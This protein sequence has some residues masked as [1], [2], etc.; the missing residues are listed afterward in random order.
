M[1][2]KDNKISIVPMIP[3]MSGNI[4]DQI[5]TIRWTNRHDCPE[6]YTFN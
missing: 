3:T 5:G 1:R 6:G 4:L 2:K